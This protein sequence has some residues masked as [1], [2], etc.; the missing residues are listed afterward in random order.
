MQSSHTEQS[1]SHP[2]PH[3][4]PASYSKAFKNKIITFANDKKLL[5]Y[6]TDLL[7]KGLAKFQSR[8]KYCIVNHYQQAHIIA[9]REFSRTKMLASGLKI[10]KQL[11]S[12]TEVRHHIQERR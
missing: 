2:I 9:P 6:L 4:Y 5:R 10:H 3:S 7:L 11:V 8:Q 1:R 12:S